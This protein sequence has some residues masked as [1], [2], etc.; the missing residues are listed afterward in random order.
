MCLNVPDPLDSLIATLTSLL[1]ARHA[2]LLEPL[3]L[4]TLLAHG[5]R[6]ATSWFRAG[7]F[8]EAFRRGYTLLGTLGRKYLDAFAS[9]LFGRLRQT[10]DPGRFWL[11]GIDDTPTQRYGPY[12]EGA[13]IHH[14]PTPGPTHQPYVYGHVWVTLDWIVR[15]PECHTLAL[16][17]QGDLYI[18][19]VDLPKIDPDRRPEFHTKLESAVAQI[20]W[21]AE[22]LC[23]TDKPIWV[24]VDGAYAKRPV[25]EA[26]RR[27]GV[28][29]IG[30]LAHNAALWDLP[31][32]VPAGQRRRG[33]PRKYGTQRLSLAKRAGHAQGWQE[34]ECFQYQKPVT[35]R[36]KTFLATWRPA[37]GV[38]G[39]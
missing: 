11:F 8:T 36:V 21:L 9:I 14:N 19:R 26:A 18:R 24:V 25:L 35:K 37:G 15:H 10:I 2:E 7:D 32:V 28:V 38:I 27:D 23:G 30:R 22:R 34:V 29:L 20:H 4:G 12:V 17:L 1:D 39:S 6:T 5:R 33:R 16:P 3:F 31:P 13:G